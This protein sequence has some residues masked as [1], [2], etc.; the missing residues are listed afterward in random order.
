MLI[1]GLKHEDSILLI[2]QDTKAELGSVTIIKPRRPGSSK[3]LLGF[4]F[5]KSIQIV[6]GELTNLGKETSNGGNR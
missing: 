6:R 2:D 5:P 3:V 4:D 1:L